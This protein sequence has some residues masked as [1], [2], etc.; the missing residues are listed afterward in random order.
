VPETKE[1]ADWMEGAFNL[2]AERWAHAYAVCEPGETPEQSRDRILRYRDQFSR[3]L[4][5]TAD[6]HVIPPKLLDNLYD[7]KK[8]GCPPQ[9]IVELML[10]STNWLGAT[11]PKLIRRLRFQKLSLQSEGIAARCQ[12]KSR[13]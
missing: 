12:R 6:Y 1:L 7:L 4:R 2:Y 9:D 8:N 10:G 3:V 13:H 11:Y 5:G